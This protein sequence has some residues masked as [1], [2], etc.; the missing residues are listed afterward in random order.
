[1][2]CPWALAWDKTH[3]HNYF[4]NSVQNKNTI[5]IPFITRSFPKQNISKIISE[6]RKAMNMANFGLEIKQKTQSIILYGDPLA[7]L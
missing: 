6:H 1:M 4:V 3:V 5:E 2:F 7:E